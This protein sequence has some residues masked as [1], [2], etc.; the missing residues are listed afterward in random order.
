MIAN[1]NSI[2][3]SA[4]YTGYCILKEIQKQEKE[5]ISIYDAS[6]A[7]KIAGIG[8]SRQL[9]IGLSFLYAVGIVDFD[10]AMIWIEK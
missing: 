7:L 5:C 6:N 3:S 1:P 8:G 9:M 4:M 2:K 10:E